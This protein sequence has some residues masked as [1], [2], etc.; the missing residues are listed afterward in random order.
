MT[1]KGLGRF[2]ALY[3]SPLFTI[4]LVMKLPSSHS[5]PR[6]N[7]G[8]SFYLLDR[9]VKGTLK[10]DEGKRENFYGRPEKE[11]SREILYSYT[12]RYLRFNRNV[13]MVK[14]V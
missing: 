8:N 11:T 5:H 3:K 2:L 9:E 14:R 10:A 4:I 13:Y 6:V 12:W 1:L 7:G